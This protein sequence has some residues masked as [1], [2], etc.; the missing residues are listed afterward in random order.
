MK[1]IQQFIFSAQ[2][3]HAVVIGAGLN[4]LEAASSLASKGLS[5][6]LV[7]AQTQI[8]PGAV[9]VPVAQHITTLA[10]QAGVSV[11]TGSK[12]VQ[13]IS[14][15]RVL[16]SVQLDNETIIVADMVIVAAGSS[17]NNELLA[18][19][20]I[21]MHCGSI[22]VS[23]H[24]QTNVVNVFAAGDI[25]AV[26]DMV[27]KKLIRSTTWSDAML[28]GLCA[29]TTLSETPRAYQGAVGLRDSFFFGAEFYACG[30]TSGV[31]CIKKINIM[32]DTS[33]EILYLGQGSVKGFVLMGDVSKVSELKRLYLTQEQYM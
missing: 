7:E 9:D 25:C 27:T 19:T 17:L 2:P 31:D 30:Q 11:V 12:V 3:Q 1:K 23:S 20:G 16:K 8:L 28:Q 6:T 29:A 5:V 32:T 18:G 13:M 22:V 15:G 14:N 4:G 10:E 33:V 24:L 21:E 26:P